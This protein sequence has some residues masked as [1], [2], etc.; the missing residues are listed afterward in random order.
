MPAAARRA[1]ASRGLM[2]KSTAGTVTTKP[3]ANTLSLYNASHIMF[4]E[5]ESLAFQLFCVSK[6][7][8]FQTTSPLAS[9]PSTQMLAYCSLQILTTLSLHPVF[10]L[11]ESR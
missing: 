4:K 6:I 1:K 5:L 9:T 8:G 10:A 11:K 7:L 2:A 3:G